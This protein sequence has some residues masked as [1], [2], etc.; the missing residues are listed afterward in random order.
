MKRK[1]EKTEFEAESSECNPSTGYP[2]T[3]GSPFQTPVSGKG[4]KTQKA[5]RSAKCNRSGSQT[6][7]AVVGECY[8]PLEVLKFILEPNL[9]IFII[10]QYSAV[11]GWQ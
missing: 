5:P 6:P 7:A 1:S 9:T 8:Q 2:E 3:F 4:G 10:L 11:K